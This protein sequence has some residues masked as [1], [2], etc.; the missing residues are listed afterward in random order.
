MKTMKYLLSLC[1]VICTSLIS[2]TSCSNDD[3]E[4]GFKFNYSD[5]AYL[6]FQE[7]GLK[8]MDFSKLTPY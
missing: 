6:H 1:L 3:E 5:R 4:T 7:E 8:R 2:L